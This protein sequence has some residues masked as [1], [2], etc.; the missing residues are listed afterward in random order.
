[1]SKSRSVILRLALPSPETNVCDLRHRLDSALSLSS[2]SSIASLRY[3]HQTSPRTARHITLQLPATTTHIDAPSNLEPRLSHLNFHPAS[4]SDS[5]RAFSTPSSPLRAPARH[6]TLPALTLVPSSLTS[7]LFLPQFPA[8]SSS[9]FLSAL[10][11]HLLPLPPLTS[12]SPLNFNTLP[13]RTPASFL[14]LM[15]G[16]WGAG[17]EG[18]HTIKAKHEVR[19]GRGP[20][21]RCSLH[22]PSTVNRLFRGSRG[23]SSEQSTCSLDIPGSVNSPGSPPGVGA[24]D[25]HGRPEHNDPGREWNRRGVSRI[26]ACTQGHCSGGGRGWLPLA[27]CAA[28]RSE[29]P[30]RDQGDEDVTS[31]Y[32]A[33]ARSSV[34]LR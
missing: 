33:V 8:C 7:S 10:F 32:R 14:F 26:A 27:L 15:L 18:V 12:P 6:T 34:S 11:L 2:L 3:A 25:D 19:G 5:L 1:M 17:G 24:H 21:M 16:G 4:S 30:L 29:K 22:H 13:S 31:W 28:W 9:Q 20:Q 23:G